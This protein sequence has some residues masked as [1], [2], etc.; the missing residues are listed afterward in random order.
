[1]LLRHFFGVVDREVCVRETVRR[2][3]EGVFGGRAEDDTDA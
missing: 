2:N 1:M 3:L